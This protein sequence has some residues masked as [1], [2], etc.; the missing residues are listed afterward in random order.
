M[1]SHLIL[2]ESFYG[3]FVSKKLIDRFDFVAVCA[4]VDVRH[5]G[6]GNKLNKLV[7]MISLRSSVAS[8]AISS[9]TMGETG[10]FC[11][12]VATGEHGKRD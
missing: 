4:A 11:R 10:N 2:F 12:L 9:T 7:A 3:F 5:R 8:V 6:V 1:V